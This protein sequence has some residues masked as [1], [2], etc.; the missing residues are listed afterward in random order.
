[1]IR[2][3]FSHLFFHWD[4]GRKK[5]YLKSNERTLAFYLGNIFEFTGERK[6]I[7]REKEIAHTCNTYCNILLPYYCFVSNSNKEETGWKEISNLIYYE[8]DFKEFRI[9]WHLWPNISFEWC[10]V[11][12]HSH[13]INF[14]SIGTEY[15]TSL[16]FFFSFREWWRFNSQSSKFI[17]VNGDLFLQISNDL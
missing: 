2:N 9:C 4:V 6:R 13:D 1:M 10:F 8:V 14:F 16:K 7:T 17:W 12:I 3:Y 5:L 11:L 15:I